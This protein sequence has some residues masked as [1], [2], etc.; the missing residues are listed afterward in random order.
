[1]RRSHIEDIIAE[2][3]SAAYDTSIWYILLRIE[4]NRGFK[5]GAKKSRQMVC[6]MGLSVFRLRLYVQ[7]ESDLC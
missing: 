6:R 3:K 2:E 4:V 5:V 7:A 1:M